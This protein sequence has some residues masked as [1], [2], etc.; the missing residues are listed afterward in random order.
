MPAAHDLT[1]AQYARLLEFRTGLRRFLHWSERR[2][3]DAGLSAA[4][5]QLLLVVRGH[6]AQEGPTIGDIAEALILKHHSAVGLVDR[7]AA[8]GLVTRRTDP[9]DHRV[10]RVRLTPKGARRL[11]ELTALHLEELARLGP[12]LR[13]LW[14]GLETSDALRG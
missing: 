9:A 11:D 12:R 14:R 10:V 6:A 2:A 1:D 13:E 5:H 4:Q 8:S 7:A 3:A